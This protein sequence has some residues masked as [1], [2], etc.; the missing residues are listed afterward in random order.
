MLGTREPE[1]YGTETLQ[2]IEALCRDEAGKY[3]MDV[4]FRQTN[5]EAELI[6]WVQQGRDTSDGLIINGAGY[7]H[8]SVALMD[9]LMAYGRPVV[10]V[11]LSNIYKREPFR[12]HSYISPAAQGIICG[13][14]AKGYAL[15]LQAITRLV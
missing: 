7:T 2:D 12:H 6:S 10:E 8:T 5:A 9:A 1:I 4:D 15:A 13:F 3:G 14:G 11:H